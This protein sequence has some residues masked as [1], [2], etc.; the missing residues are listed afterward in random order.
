[1]ASVET[2]WE[3]RLRMHT[4]FPSALWFCLAVLALRSAHAEL[5]IEGTN[6]ILDIVRLTQF[7][8]PTEGQCTSLNTILYPMYQADLESGVIC[9]PLKGF[10]GN[11]QDRVIYI[12]DFL[13]IVGCEPEIAFLNLMNNALVKGIIVGVDTDPGS[14]AYV[15][16]GSMGANTLGINSVFLLEVHANR[17]DAADPVYV[18]MHS[19]GSQ[20]NI[21]ITNTCGDANPFLE[22]YS[23]GP[24]KALRIT[25]LVLYIFLFLYGTEHFVSFA[26]RQN[27][28]PT[29]LT[30]TFLQTVK[31]LP[32]GVLIYLGIPNTSPDISFRWSVAL[33]PQFTGI[34]VFCYILVGLH[35]REQRLQT[36]ELKTYSGIWQKHRGFI[37]V[38]ALLTVGIDLVR[39][40]LVTASFD[41]NVLFYVLLELT[42]VIIAMCYTPWVF[43]ETFYF[44]RMLSEFSKS[45]SKQETAKYH[46][47]K[48]ARINKILKHMS[49]CLSAAG[50]F[51][52]VLLVAQGMDASGFSNQVS[53]VSLTL[54]LTFLSRYFISFFLVAALTPPKSVLWAKIGVTKSQ[55][56]SKS[57]LGV[58]RNIG[59]SAISNV[60]GPISQNMPGA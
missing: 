4:A 15:Q 37:G 20:L 58:S 52:V 45:A 31:A 43:Q 50:F 35:F 32:V 40:I 21:T 25:G 12:H 41:N 46:K 6:T 14:N 36:A 18:P 57:S 1:M 23:F 27:K 7:I 47:N 39:L 11:Y 55:E 51:V 60:I 26:V 9:S 34:D 54:W 49:L 19:I 3:F 17:D 38:V 56:V 59:K 30:I 28:L 48:K 42:Y 16:D 33:S 5:I 22:V 53:T 13:N 44:L 10:L 24:I 2:N 29:N 8:G